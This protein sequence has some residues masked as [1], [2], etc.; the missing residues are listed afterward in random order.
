MPPSLFSILTGVITTSGLLSVSIV[1]I[2]M[3]ALTYMRYNAHDPESKIFDAQQVSVTISVR[4]NSRRNQKL[5]SVSDSFSVTGIF[6]D[7]IT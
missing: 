1:P 3:I 6:Y 4:N 2:V 5:L 7:A